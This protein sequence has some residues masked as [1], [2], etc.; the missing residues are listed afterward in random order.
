MHV[1]KRL[2]PFIADCVSLGFRTG[3]LREQSSTAKPDS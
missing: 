3:A 1:L 2:L